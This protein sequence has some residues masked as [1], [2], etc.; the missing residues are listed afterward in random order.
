MFFQEGKGEEGLTCQLRNLGNVMVA[1]LMEREHI[2]PESRGLTELFRIFL[3]EDGEKWVLHSM[4]ASFPPKADI[5]NAPDESH[6]TFLCFSCAVK[7]D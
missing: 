7:G 5:S 3:E 1:L 2:L 4:V 6:P